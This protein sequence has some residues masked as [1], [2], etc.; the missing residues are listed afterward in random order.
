[1][2]MSP[3]QHARVRQLYFGE[4]WKVGTIASELGLHADAVKR[5]LE[6]PRFGNRVEA[7]RPS[8]LDPFKP[9]VL[10]TLD[11]HPRLRSSRL[12][13]MLQGRGY[14]GGVA[15][16][17]RYVA[18]V[19]PASLSEGFLALETLPG[20]QGQVDWAHCGKLRVGE[21]LRPLLLFVMVLSFSRRI[22][23]RFFLD[24]QMDNFRRGHVE[25]FEHFG[26]VPRELLYDNLKSVVLDRVGE[27]VRFHPQVLELASHYCYAPKPC[28]VYRGNEKGKAERAIQYMRTS[29]LEARDYRD[30]DDLN[31]Q[32]QG[33]N[34]QVADV[35]LHPTDVEKRS[36]SECFEQEQPCLLPLP[37]HSFECD[38]VL[39][40]RSGKRPYLRFDGNDYSIPHTLVR[41]P[42]TLV[43]SDKVVRVLDGDKLVA[44]HA[45]CYDRRRRIEDP[46]HLQGLIDHKR[47]AR[48]VTGRDRILSV[49]KHADGFYQQLAL[50]GANIGAVTSRLLRLL[51]TY[52]AQTLDY[53]LGE[54]LSR[55]AIGASAIAHLCEQRRRQQRR[56]VPLPPEP[57]LHPRIAQLRVVS[58]DLHSYDSLASTGDD[59]NDGGDDER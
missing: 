49:S 26:G 47:A 21:A 58:H 37:E 16:L 20:E 40:K 27:H 48:Q 10:A 14:K 51:D 35:R 3:E 32:L 6:T 12:L 59:D 45:R 55:E 36:V 8:M 34:R 52:G 53:A 54:A 4:H 33:W 28:A 31:S 13:Q 11:Q 38:R 2:T 42:V 19:R 57:A 5:A 29:F 24:A 23:A 9:F 44:Q 15:T 56:L 1:M 41:K 50:R 25:A 18:T 17:R 7:L 46:A 30:L 43:T 39:P 22:F